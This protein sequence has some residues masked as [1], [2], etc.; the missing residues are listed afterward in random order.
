MREKK[1]IHV[2]GTGTLGEPMINLLLKLQMDLDVDEI[3]FHKNTP[4]SDDRVRI[5]N[6]MRLGGKL[7]VEVEKMADFEKIGLQPTYTRQE[8]LEQAAV[9]IDC[10][11]EGHG[12][13]HKEN[14]YRHLSKPRGFIAQ[15]SEFGFGKMYAHGIND[16]VL[17]PG[18]DRYLQVVSCNTH[19]LAVLINTLALHDNQ[20][21]N[22]IEG[23]FVC[24]R[25]ATDLSQESSFVPAPDVGKHS[26]NKFGTH[27]AKDAWHLF[28]TM[29]LDL[30]LFSSAI[31][32]NTQYMHSLWFNL[33][34]RETITRSEVLDRLHANPYV[35]L[36]EKTMSSPIFSFGR[37]HGYFG[38]LL[39][40]TVISVP[41]I[42]VR[43]GHEITGFCFTP[44]DGNSLLSSIAAAAWLLDPN[45][46]EEHIRFM[47]PYLFD[48]L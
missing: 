1:T 2:V 30:D 29:N 43:D 16:A 8:A 11:A 36:T 7:A 3:T 17:V 21:G 28:Q 38:R 32:I 42:S 44:Q 39:N 18:E 9:V 48:E 47:T 4:R 15:G 19:N 26:D 14:W 34:L 12:L 25:R 46:Y 31:K 5:Q 27:H 24:M 33:R 45:H 6:L 40:Q 35:A 37:D 41:T 22:L 20:P 23:R 13:D 10:T